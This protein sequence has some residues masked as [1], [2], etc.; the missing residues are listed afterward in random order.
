MLNDQRF[1]KAS[2]AVVKIAAWFF[3]FL[4]ILGAATMFFGPAQATPRWAG[5]I[6]LAVYIFGFF[7][8]RLVAKLA[9]ILAG[10]LSAAGKL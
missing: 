1:L 3:L 4:G 10:M 2:S 5:F 7:F 8:L 6:I 9:D